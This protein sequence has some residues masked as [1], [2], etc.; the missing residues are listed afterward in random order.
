MVLILD[1]GSVILCLWYTL[2]N[3]AILG[4]QLKSPLRP[5]FPALFSSLFI[6]AVALTLPV[7]R[8]SHVI[9]EQL[10]TGGWRSLLCGDNVS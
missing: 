8:R 1:L 5:L 6:L 4:D 7:L 3:H 2:S 9:S 10:L